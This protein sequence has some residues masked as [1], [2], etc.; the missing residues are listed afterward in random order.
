MTRRYSQVVLLLAVALLL[1]GEATSQVG[2]KD[3]GD[4]E[5]TVF[6]S[7]GKTMSYKKEVRQLEII[8]DSTGNV[9]NLHMVLALS[10]EKDSHIWLNYHNLAGFQYRY[11][12]ISGRA[13]VHVRKHIDYPIRE[14]KDKK[15]E[16]IDPDDYR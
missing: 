2:A 5:V 9:S 3:K 7:N 1:P 8:L 4:L 16:A 10:A 13:K 11:Y 14:K 15:L 6:L 12:A